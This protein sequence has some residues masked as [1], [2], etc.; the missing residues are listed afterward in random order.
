MTGG[1]QAKVLQFRRTEEDE[2]T[3][4][5]KVALITLPIQLTPGIA[6]TF[7]VTY[8]TS[9]GAVTT[10]APQ[11]QAF[12]YSI[13][14]SG[15]KEKEVSELRDRVKAL[16]DRLA[17][18]EKEQDSKVIL[19]RAISRE[20]ARTEILRLFEENQAEILDYGII[21]ERLQMDLQIVVDVCNELEQEGLIG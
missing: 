1:A 8:G 5:D 18:I 11:F 12:S 6:H 7:S 16:E 15:I 10:E 3:I 19:L 2:T 17:A 14:S 4:G 13:P 9:E 20:D 21:A